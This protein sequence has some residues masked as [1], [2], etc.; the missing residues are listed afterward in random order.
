MASRMA[1]EE[2]G[3]RGENPINLEGELTIPPTTKCVDIANA[4]P[5]VFGTEIDPKYFNA[6]KRDCHGGWAKV[7]GLQKFIALPWTKRREGDLHAMDE[8][9]ENYDKVTKTT[10]WGDA[11]VSLTIDMLSTIFYLEGYGAK[12]N[13]PKDC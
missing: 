3:D 9:I 1:E 10:R 2:P 6:M 7:E 11:T 5:G 13:W 4:P 12:K 8:M